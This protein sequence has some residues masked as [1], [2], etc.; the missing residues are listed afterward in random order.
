MSTPM[1]RCYAVGGLVAQER[2][3]P[4]PACGDASGHG[5]WGALITCAHC[6]AS[7]CV[8]WS[9][10]RVG[11]C[12]AC[13]CGRE[14]R[15][16]DVVLGAYVRGRAWPDASDVERRDAELAALR[17]QLA[18]ARA[19]LE[20]L[21]KRADHDANGKHDIRGYSCH[22]VRAYQLAVRDELW[23]LVAALGPAVSS[24]K[25]P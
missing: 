11:E 19:A 2:D 22:F 16:V 5:L 8:P 10:V 9:T 4:C 6:G 7:R 14:T 13:A 15:L 12:Y 20:S 18:T 23:K 3:Q 25:G 17:A 21:A 24:P 1:R